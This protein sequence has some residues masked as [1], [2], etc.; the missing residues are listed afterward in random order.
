MH[1]L[2]YRVDFT[3]EIDHPGVKKALIRVHER[4]L[5]KYVF[6]G[7]LL[8]NT[9]RLAQVKLSKMSND[10]MATQ[11]LQLFFRQPLE[12]ASRRTSDETD[13]KITLDFKNE[14]QAGDPVYNSVSFKKNK[15]IKCLPIDK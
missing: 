14:I 9:T 1:L 3:P 15:I 10:P 5:G 2:Q 11:F 4:T 13:V 7:T 8:Y 12:L 6:D